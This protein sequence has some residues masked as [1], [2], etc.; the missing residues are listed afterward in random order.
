MNWSRP[1]QLP[2][3]GQNFLNPL[4]SAAWI[5]CTECDRLNDGA[6]STLQSSNKVKAG[7][8]WSKNKDDLS[9]QLAELKTELSQLRIQKIVSS[10]TK[11][12]KMYGASPSIFPSKSRKERS[13][14]DGR[15]GK[16]KTRAEH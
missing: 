9:K 1:I 4:A 7:P 14:R 3:F 5:D 16:W 2:L 13:E 10:G 6:N 12:N 8:L 11:L 15:E